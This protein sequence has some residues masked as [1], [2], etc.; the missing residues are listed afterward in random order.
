M[1]NRRD[2]SHDQATSAA[3]VWYL[4]GKKRNLTT[5]YTG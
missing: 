1:T 4:R 3:R 5:T 2:F